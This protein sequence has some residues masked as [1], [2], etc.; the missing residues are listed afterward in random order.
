MKDYEQ[1][2]KEGLADIALFEKILLNDDG[3]INMY[4]PKDESL[5]DCDNVKTV[6]N[7][8]ETQVLGIEIY[9]DLHHQFNGC[10]LLLSM[11]GPTSYINTQQG[12]LVNSFGSE[13]VRLDLSDS[14]VD[15]IDENIEFL[16]NKRIIPRGQ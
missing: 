12:L 1:L 3:S 7:L 8:I 4:D 11:N 6:R 5:P 13:E 9:T 15:A 2:K 10:E 16:Y 14:L